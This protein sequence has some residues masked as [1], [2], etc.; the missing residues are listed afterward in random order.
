MDTQKLLAVDETLKKVQGGDVV[1]SRLRVPDFIEDDA[2]IFIKNKKFLSK[3]KEHLKEEKIHLVI[4]ESFYKEFQDELTVLAQSLF[5][6]PN[7][8]FSIPVISKIFYD[9]LFEGINHYVDGRQMGTA[10]VHPSTTMS[11]HVFLGENVSI[12][13]NCMIHPQ[14][15]IMAGA[16]IGDNTEIF[17]HVVIAPNVVIGRR[18][19]IHS[20]ASLGQDGFGYNYIDDI[21]YKIWH[22]GSLIIEDDV[23]VG[24]GTCIDGGTFGPTMVGEGTKIDNQVQIGHNC[25]IGKGVILCGQ[26]GLAGSVRIGDFS[27]LGGRVGMTDGTSIGSHCRVAGGAVVTHDWPKK[28]FIGG[29]PARNLS[30]WLKGVAYVRKKSLEKSA[31]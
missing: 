22:M 31:S 30:E 15:T 6:T 2:L 16:K 11:Q 9:E 7:I 18:V 26:V 8:D 21:H 28:S 12:G 20:N 1:F 29:H 17:P 23:E 4:P 5:T 25:F 3:L 27:F 13:K 24:A 10:Y 14:V 19:R